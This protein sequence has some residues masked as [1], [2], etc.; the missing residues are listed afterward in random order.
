MQGVGQKRR[1]A[2]G[3]LPKWRGGEQRPTHQGISAASVNP[4][5]YSSDRLCAYRQSRSDPVK[6]DPPSSFLPADRS[7]L[8]ERGSGNGP[9][10]RSPFFLFLFPFKLRPVSWDCT[11]SHRSIVSDTIASLQH[12][13]SKLKPSAIPERLLCLEMPEPGRRVGE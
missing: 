11:M 3:P 12:D 7:G 2:P 13:S 6:P 9:A 8:L 10:C 1:R 4:T 5:H